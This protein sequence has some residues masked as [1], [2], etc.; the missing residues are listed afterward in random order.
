MKQSKP[1]IEGLSEAQNAWFKREQEVKAAEER[2][3]VAE[4]ASQKRIAA[5]EQREAEAKAAEEKMRWA[6]TNPIEFAEAA[7]MTQEQW[8]E[9]M[10]NGGKLTPEQE[11]TRS[12]EKR[13]EQV[14]AQNEKLQRDQ[15]DFIERSA[16][17]REDAAFSS[18]LSAYAFVERMGG[19]PMVRQ[20]QHAMSQSLG[21][22]V[23]LHEAAKALESELEAGINGLLKHEGIRSKL[24]LSD[25]NKSKPGPVAK[26]PSTLNNRT[27]SSTTADRS[28]PGKLAWDDWAGKRERALKLMREAQSAN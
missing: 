25:V 24:K 18:Q 2:A 13:L 6:R 8:K 20:K 26:S 11:R 4:T 23:P 12:I 9:L 1:N 27:A 10:A 5:A 28:E 19:L 14:M 15:Q 22:P 17:E 16:R 7:G 21:T 3:R